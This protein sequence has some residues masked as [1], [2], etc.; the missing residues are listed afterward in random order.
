[1]TSVVHIILCEMHDRGPAYVK[2][3]VISGHLAA[4]KCGS[5]GREVFKN[6]NYRLYVIQIVVIC[7]RLSQPFRITNS[8]WLTRECMC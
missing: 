2:T 5:V 8:G 6:H 7:C 4:R 3:K 1:M